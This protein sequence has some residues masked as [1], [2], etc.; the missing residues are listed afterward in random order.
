LPE[1]RGYS[2]DNSKIIGRWGYEGTLA[3]YVGTG[4]LGELCFGAN[5]PNNRKWN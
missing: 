2:T 1:V 5:D 3:G 4:T